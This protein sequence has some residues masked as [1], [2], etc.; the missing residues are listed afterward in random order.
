MRHK[1][2]NTE[3]NIIPQIKSFLESAEGKALSRDPRYLQLFEK[4]AST[5]ATGVINAPVQSS[6]NT[7]VANTIDTT[8]SVH[9]SQHEDAFPTTNLTS[10]PNLNMT[11]KMALNCGG[12]SSDCNYNLPLLNKTFSTLQLLQD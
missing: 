8:V 1:R 7:A 4:P 6:G 9:A 5:T 12:R 3:G 2:Q 10:A 11:S